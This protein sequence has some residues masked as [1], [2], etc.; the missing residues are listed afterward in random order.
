[1][2]IEISDNAI[3]EVRRMMEKEGVQAA[4]LRVGVKG[5]GCSG[6]SYNLTFETQGTGFASAGFFLQENHLR[7]TFLG[8]CTGCCIVSDSNGI[9][10]VKGIEGRS[11]TAAASE[12]AVRSPIPIEAGAIGVRG[13]ALSVVVLFPPKRPANQSIKPLLFFFAMRSVSGA[14]GGT[15]FIG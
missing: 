8:L 3:H 15:G 1:M 6:L 10:G 4:G 7:F 13:R 11:R 5:G 12:T 9:A 2:A 14:F